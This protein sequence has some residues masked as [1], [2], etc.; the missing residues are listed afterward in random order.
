M[1]Q[2]YVIEAPDSSKDNKNETIACFRQF[3]AL[4]VQNSSF[5]VDCVCPPPCK[6]TL[7]EVSHKR[8][9]DIGLKNSWLL[10]IR[11]KS[12]TVQ[13]MKEYER[14]SAEELISNVG[15]L[16]GLFLGMS[17][18]SLAEIAFHAVISIIKY[19]LKVVNKIYR[20]TLTVRI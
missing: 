16:C 14:Y 20:K 18:L 10:K 1:F 15:G 19:S 6:E 4:Y 17:I 7:Y 12:K 9:S 13:V 8:V 11:F 2:D 5:L 3:Y